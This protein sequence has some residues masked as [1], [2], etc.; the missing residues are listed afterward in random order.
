[1]SVVRK[2]ARELTG[3]DG[4]TFVLR[5]E[6]KCFYAEEDAISP[7]WR[8]Q[9]F[10]MKSCISGWVM[11]NA[12]SVMIEDIYADP[13]IP[14]DAYRPTFVKSLAMVPI[15]KEKPIG[16]IGNYWAVQ[17]KTTERELTLLQALA[18]ATSVALENVDLYRQLQD[19]ITALER[20]NSELDRFVWISS[21]D[22]KSPLRAIHHISEWIESDMAAQLTDESRENFAKMHQRIQRM[23]KLL[24][25]LLE[26][27][28]LDHAAREETERLVDG[29][30]LL[31]EILQFIYVPKGFSIQASEEFSRV[32]VPF[33][34]MHRIFCNL[35]DN[36]I[37]HHDG[38]AGN[39]KIDVKDAGSHYSFTVTDDGPGIPIPYREKIFE[40]FQTLKPRDV[41]EGS[42]M[43]LALV[44]KMLQGYGEI[45][46]DDA[47]PRGAIFRFTWPKP[48]GNL[49]AT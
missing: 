37:K 44:K 22:L 1:M 6:D 33:G 12:S 8:G 30:T 4:A 7:L 16:A 26:Y 9:R 19:K 48:L 40:V 45:C 10:P 13:R 14:A 2:A 18:D 20:S 42:G 5:D 36:A 35:L 39:I 31:E 25:D 49:P 21:H 15:R 28:K 32:T 17:R 41:V 47:K 29:N 34:P 46:V 24:N 23:D 3:A 11:M 43:G 38:K 27:A